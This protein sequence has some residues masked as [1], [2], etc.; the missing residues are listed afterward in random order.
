MYLS[1]AIDIRTSM[2]V[3]NQEVSFGEVFIMI[4]PDMIK[5][6]ARKKKMYFTLFH[7]VPMKTDAIDKHL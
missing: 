1:A 5:R 7:S 3:I 6:F 2:E 4:E